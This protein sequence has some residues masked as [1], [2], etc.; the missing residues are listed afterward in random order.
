MQKSI[1]TAYIWIVCT[2]LLL[3]FGTHLGGCEIKTT[4]EVKAELTQH[5]IHTE[6]H[7]HSDA[8]SLEKTQ[9]D[10]GQPE[11]TKEDTAQEQTPE[12]ITVQNCPRGQL[13]DDAQRTCIPFPT[14]KLQIEELQFTHAKDGVQL[15]GTLLKPQVRPGVRL[16]AIIFI[17]GSGPSD[18]DATA[19][20]ALGLR[21]PKPVKVFKDIAKY[22]A[23]KG[24][25][26]FRY[27]KRTYTVK[28]PKVAQKWTVD[29]FTEDASAALDMLQKRDDV[30]VNDLT[31]MG[32]SQGGSLVLDLG[33]QRPQIKSIVI[34][35]GPAGS[36]KSLLVDQYK[37]IVEWLEKSPPS[38]QRDQQIKVNKDKAAQYEK[39]L[40]AIENETY[41]QKTFEGIPIVF[42]K[43]WIDNHKRIPQNIKQLK[44]PL[45]V[46]SGTLDFNVKPDQTKLLQTWRGTQPKDFFKIYD[47]LTH[48]LIKVVGQNAEEHVHQELLHDVLKWMNAQ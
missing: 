13:F 5:E 47:G 32:Y 27:D 14:R 6:L 30:Q 46:V 10:A 48:P 42:W 33:V 12:R 7:Q 28:D 20:G 45:A 23:S 18:R 22:F 4:N 1:R 24:Y 21:L 35:A 9:R 2:F 26:V 3:L 17:H 25:V 34:L 37:Q 40:T 19:S 31:V 11:P 8:G 15:S 44:Q 39:V 36:L 16:P 29:S 41:T 38:P 43:S